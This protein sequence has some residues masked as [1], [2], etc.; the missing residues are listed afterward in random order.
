MG[1]INLEYIFKDLW[2]HEA[3]E[4]SRL[5]EN[6]FQKVTFWVTLGSFFIALVI[7]ISTN[8]IDHHNIQKLVAIGLV[9]LSQLSALLFQLSFVFSGFRILKEPIRLILKPLTKL[10]VRDYELAL[11]MSRFD[12]SQLN[13]AKSR[14]ALESK[15]M[16]SRV[17][18]LVGAIDKVGILPV[19]V[20]WVFSAYKYFHDNK[21][22][23]S[24]VD[25]LVYG[26]M[27][28][29]IVAILAFF[30]THKI[31]RYILVIDT[32]QNFKEANNV[33]NSDN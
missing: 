16:K 1:L 27:G 7:A 25:W 24:E 29:Y 11:S 21:L 30:F 20:T 12:I 14:L 23:F 6:N 22:Q 15:H 18:I 31:E 9:A 5:F 2:E 8:F 4:K 32:A 10:A 13:Y 28:I 33:I 3:K 19:V 26:L 17:N